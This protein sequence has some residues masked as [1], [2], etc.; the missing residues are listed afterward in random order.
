MMLFNV[1][2]IM[3]MDFLYVSGMS[4]LL[5]L[6]LFGII[7]PLRSFKKHYIAD[8]MFY[9]KNLFAKMKMKLYVLIINS[10][11]VIIEQ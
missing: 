3:L 5:F 4:I 10:V 9:I 11:K 7:K 2:A 8:F 6:Q 1:N